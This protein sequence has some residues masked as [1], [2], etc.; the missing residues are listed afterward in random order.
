MVVMSGVHAGLALPAWACDFAPSDIDTLNELGV[1]LTDVEKD[2]QDFKERKQDQQQYDAPRSA[3]ERLRQNLTSAARRFMDPAAF[4][5]TV[6]ECC[7][8]VRS[9]VCVPARVCVRVRA[10]PVSSEDACMVYGVTRACDCVPLERKQEQRSGTQWR[11]RLYPPARFR[12][13]RLLDLDYAPFSETKFLL[14]RPRDSDGPDLPGHA[15][16]TCKY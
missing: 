1:N 14:R 15:F 10:F 5:T 2:L 9:R 6:R 4:M 7:E 11:L 12:R 13:F 3:A 16:T 8:C